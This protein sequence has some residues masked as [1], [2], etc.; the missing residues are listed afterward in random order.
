[1]AL[2][3]A[4]SATLTSLGPFRT[5]GPCLACKSIIVKVMSPSQEC[6]VIHSRDREAVNGPGIDAR[7]W[8]KRRYTTKRS[9]YPRSETTRNAGVPVHSKSLSLTEGDII[10]RRTLSAMFD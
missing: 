2:M 7:G 9:P 8:K 4:M 6:L 3:A 10:F 5:R 1:M